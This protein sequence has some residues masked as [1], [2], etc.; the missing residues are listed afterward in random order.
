VA[1]E[2]HE[3][4]DESTNVRPF[5]SIE[6]PVIEVAPEEDADV[7]GFNEMTVDEVTL[8]EEV[9]EDEDARTEDRDL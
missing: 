3:A 1:I 7:P 8:E 6:E 4:D 9:F 5:T 2:G